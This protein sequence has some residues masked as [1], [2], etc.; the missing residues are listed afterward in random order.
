VASET[1]A[2]AS[3][4]SC[5]LRMGPA[6]EKPRKVLWLARSLQPLPDRPCSRRVRQLRVRER[7]CHGF[8]DW[9]SVLKPDSLD[10][11]NDNFDRV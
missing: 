4:G 6:C 7:Y 1:P 2:D 11:C 9:R 5:L 8:V 10:P 3:L